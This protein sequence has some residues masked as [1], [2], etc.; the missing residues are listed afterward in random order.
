MWLF[1]VGGFVSVVGHREKA[2]TVVVRARAYEHLTEF[3]ANEPPT[4][5]GEQ[6][7]SREIHE[8]TDRDY[9]W[10]VF[11]PVEAFTATLTAIGEDVPT[12][13]NFKGACD[14]AGAPRVWKGVLSKVWG[15]LAAFQDRTHD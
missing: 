14:Q 4:S 12:Y 6:P 8:T 5:S 2:G 10:R 9:R 1:F 11:M 13:P 7:P 3:L 15:L